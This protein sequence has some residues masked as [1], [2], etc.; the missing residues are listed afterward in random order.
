MA[1]REHPK[2]TYKLDEAVAF[3]LEPNSDSDMSDLEDSKDDEYIPD[4]VEREMDDEVNENEEN[5]LLMSDEASDD[6]GE[7]NEDKCENATTSRLTFFCFVCI[8]FATYL[9]NSSCQMLQY[10]LEI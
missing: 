3:V 7:N 9:H 8:R 5:D 1:T 4:I 2:R 10:L 6:D